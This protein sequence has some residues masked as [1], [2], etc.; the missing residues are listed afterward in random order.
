M[1]CGYVPSFT[2]KDHK[3]LKSLGNK[4]WSKTGP[5]NFGYYQYW[6]KMELTKHEWKK[7]KA[8]IHGYNLPVELHSGALGNLSI[9]IFANSDAPAINPESICAIGQDNIPDFSKY[10]GY[11]KRHPCAWKIF[12]PITHSKRNKELLKFY[13]LKPLVERNYYEY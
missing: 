3:W 10:K 5:D 4:I 12:S 7:V 8:L 2:L 9:F 11:E 13:R 6:E 1:V